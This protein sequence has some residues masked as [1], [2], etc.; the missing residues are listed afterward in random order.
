MYTIK[1]LYELE[2]LHKLLKS[3]ALTEEEYE[4]SKEKVMNAIFKPAFTTLDDIETA[5]KL[6]D[7]EI[8][9][10]SEFDAI[11]LQALN[12]I[13]PKPRKTK[14]KPKSGKYN[15]CLGS[16]L[17]FLIF[18]FVPAGCSIACIPSEQGGYGLA[19]VWIFVAIYIWI[20]MWWD[21]HGYDAIIKK[22]IIQDA[23]GKKKW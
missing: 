6:K 19:F 22:Q 8:L 12:T 17:A 15:S 7:Q 1:K 9:S 21:R 5:K 4:A 20:K 10:E 23:L 2:D 11:K 13:E 18:A 14:D 3:G 16:L